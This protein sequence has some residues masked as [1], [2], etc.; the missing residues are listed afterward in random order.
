M[1]IFT[2]N[3]IFIVH[4]NENIGIILYHIVIRTLYDKEDIQ[5]KQS[6][7]VYH[8]VKKLLSEIRKYG[9]SEVSV[10]QYQVV[11][12]SVLEFFISKEIETYSD[13]LLAEY[14]EMVTKR[15]DKGDICSEYLRFQ[16]RVIRMLKSLAST[17]NVDFSVAN[18]RKKYK[19]SI[20]TAHLV[21]DILDDNKLE[22]ETRYEM[23]IVLRHF[24]FY[25]E[26][27]K[28]SVNDISDGI[29]MKF[30]TKEI[31]ITNQGSI[32]RTLRGIKYISSYLKSHGRSDLI[33]DFNQ[34]KI[35]TGSV[36]MIPPYSHDEII[37][38]FEAV[39]RG[40]PEGLR[41]Y[42]IL[43][44]GFDTGLRGVDIRTLC[45]SDINWEL[46]TVKIKQC[47]TSETLVL[48]LSYRVMNAIADYIL[49]ARYECKYK[50][51]FLNIKKPVRPMNKRYY[52]FTSIITKYCTKAGVEIKPLRGFHSLRRSFA[53]ELSMAGVPIGIISQ[54]LGHKRIDED[55]PYLSYN[56]E[57]IAFCSMDFFEIPLENGLYATASS[58]GGDCH[59][60]L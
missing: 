23:D 12:N 33:L 39:D 54:L 30:L 49:K 37:K 2:K 47:K 26:Y 17:G 43:L 24:F 56:R 34:L 40:T 5:M 13:T 38:M 31:P 35:K 57:Q 52:A 11:C 25:A 29:F 27:H 48:P 50:E 28:I 3:H 20:E 22:G 46:G 14:T 32:G 16:K 6:I 58:I 53:T 4:F 18:S 9:I 42:A 7:K 19:V 1:P 36:K 10:E 59:D 15:C 51:I 44:L 21:A 41:D 55:K 8:L 60:I 45:L